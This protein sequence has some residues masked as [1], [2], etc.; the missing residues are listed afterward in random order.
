MTLT[1][2]PDAPI[3]SWQGTEYGFI[4]RR[5][6]TFFELT[7]SGA[8][9]AQVKI[10]AYPFS[11]VLGFTKTASAQ[12]RRNIA[13]NAWRTLTLSFIPGTNFNEQRV[14]LSFGPLKISLAGKSLLFE[15]TSATINA[16]KL[17]GNVLTTDGQTPHYIY[18]NLRSDYESTF[19][20]RITFG[21]ARTQQWL[22]GA[23]TR[24]DG[25]ENVASFTTTNNSPLFNRTDAAQIILGDLNR[26]MSAEAQIGFVRLF[27]YELD[28]QDIVRDIRNGWQMMYY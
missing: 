9:P 15:Y 14:L 2:E 18:V 1:Q 17:C 23:I 24:A 25:N 28:E 26:V 4:E 13:A 5:M 27:D 3:L 16:R 8:A 21:V 11:T 22:S 20:N 7:L 6:P 19:P 12:V 10:Q